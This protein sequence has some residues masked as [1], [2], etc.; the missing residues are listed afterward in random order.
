[1]ASWREIERIRKDAEGF[2]GLAARLL[3]HTAPDALTDWEATFIREIAASNAPEFTNRQSEK[4]LEIRDNVEHVDKIG[5]GFS[6]AKL[7]EG[8]YLARLDLTEDQEEWIVALHSKGEKS[9]R[10]RDAGKLLRC[11]RDLGLIDD[12]EAA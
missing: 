12:A 6:V 9:V 5:R 1:M 8:C 4:L 2:R 3:A 7:I 10:R 11:A